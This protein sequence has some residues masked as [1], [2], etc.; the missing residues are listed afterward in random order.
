MTTAEPATGAG[1]PAALAPPVKVVLA[2]VA[3][4]ACPET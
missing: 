2:R 1:L 4:K 3:S